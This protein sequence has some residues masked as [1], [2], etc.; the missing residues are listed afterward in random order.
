MRD[1]QLRELLVGA[2]YKPTAPRGHILALLATRQGVFTA[3]ELLEALGERAP[4]VGRATLFRTLDIL[5]GLGALERVRLPGGQE[6]YLLCDPHHHHH[7]VC[8]SCG[9]IGEVE[10]GALERT[11]TAAVEDSG[12]TLRSHAL[13]LS[14]VCA[15]CATH[16]F[17]RPAR[18][19]S[20]MDG[21]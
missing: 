9:A 14:G 6:A 18:S 5:I 19:A 17:P 3:A 21:V 10:S 4:E 1:D 7:V 16:D 12:F 2:G 20:S 15:P 13:E 11:L 8:T